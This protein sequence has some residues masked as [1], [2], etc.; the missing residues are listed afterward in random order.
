[1]Q[2]QL[3]LAEKARTEIEAGAYIGSGCKLVAPLRIGEGAT[4]GAGS[5]VT[6]DVPAGK[7]ALARSRQIT[8][9]NWERPDRKPK[10]K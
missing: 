10:D 4:I 7:L 8:V 5:T 6:Q 1:M 9:E 2:G 3:A